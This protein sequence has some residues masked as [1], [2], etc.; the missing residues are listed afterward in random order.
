MKWD[1]FHDE[2]NWYR[3]HNEMR[4]GTMRHYLQG[5]SD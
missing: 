5:S 1:E 2:G 3:V 4:G